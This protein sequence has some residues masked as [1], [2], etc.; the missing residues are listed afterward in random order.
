MKFIF[1]ILSLFTLN[2]VIAQNLIQHLLPVNGYIIG[3]TNGDNGINVFTHRKSKTSNAINSYLIKPGQKPSLQ[4][5][6]NVNLG[7]EKI[8]VGTF[9]GNQIYVQEY[10]VN[11][12]LYKLDLLILGRNGRVKIVN[13][14]TLEQKAY[15]SCENFT[16]ENIGYSSNEKYVGIGYL[17]NE[18]MHAIILDDSFNVLNSYSFKD[19]N[20][21][22]SSSCSIDNNG[23]LTYTA[24]SKYRSSTSGTVNT[25]EM[26]VFTTPI[27]GETKLDLIKWDKKRESVLFPFNY[28]GET[29]LLLSEKLSKDQAQYTLY[30]RSDAGFIPGKSFIKT[31]KEKVKQLT[32]IKINT[33]TSNLIGSRWYKGTGYEFGE[34]YGSKDLFEVIISEGAILDIRDTKTEKLHHAEYFFSYLDETYY[35]YSCQQK[36]KNARKE[37]SVV[38]IEEMSVYLTTSNTSSPPTELLPSSKMMI[39]G[40]VES[41]GVVYFV[42]YNGNAIHLNELHMDQ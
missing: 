25:N 5:S 1:L 9:K 22:A 14:K 28:Q 40:V 36:F 24:F 13:I 37:G 18:E 20:I 27:T 32:Q 29:M 39:T 11:P 15:N 10:K 33:P 35:L 12:K 38:S 6:K 41:Q 8:Y 16:Y 42:S 31:H 19:K 21:E 2:N 3:L 23:T 30:S 7:F 4:S 26:L 17:M 34:G